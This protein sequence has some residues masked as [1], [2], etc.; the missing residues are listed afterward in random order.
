MIDANLV[1]STKKNF[2]TIEEFGDIHKKSI[3]HQE[4]EKQEFKDW[5]KEQPMSK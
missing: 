5:E 4:K 2:Y 1:Y 3:I